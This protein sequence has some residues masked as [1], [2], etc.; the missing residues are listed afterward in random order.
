MIAGKGVSKNKPEFTRYS[1]DNW[2]AS[3][4]LRQGGGR[5][6]T[7]R[8]KGEK[9]GR[10]GKGGRREGRRPEFNSQH[11]YLLAGSQ[12]PGILFRGI[13]CPL[14][15]PEVLHPSTS[16]NTRPLHTD[17]HTHTHTLRTT[18]T[19]VAVARKQALEEAGGCEAWECGEWHVPQLPEQ[20][21]VRS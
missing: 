2:K 13:P 15:H 19:H 17:T 5:G 1:L 18:A 8:R 11:L 16:P 9:R 20:R 10:G 4:Y 7:K 14:L 21:Q 12:L 3:G 6:G